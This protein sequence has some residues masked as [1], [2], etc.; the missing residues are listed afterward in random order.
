VKLAIESIRLSSFARSYR[1]AFRSGHGGRVGRL[2]QLAW[3]IRF[4]F[5]EWTGLGGREPFA[6]TL[7]IR[8]ESKTLHLNGRN[9]QTRCVYFSI[10]DDGYEV[11]VAMTIDRFL[12]DDGVFLDVGSNWGYFTL[13]VSSQAS[14]RGTIHA[15]E[16]MPGSYADL[17][18]VTGEAG[19]GKW[20]ET[21]QMAVGDRQGTVRMKDTR[22]SALAHV[23]DSEKGVEVPSGTIDQFEWDR[24]DVIKIDTEGYEL[25]ALQGAARSIDRCRPVIVFENETRNRS[26]ESLAPLRFLEERGY[27]LYR[28][29]ILSGELAFHP[30]LSGERDRHPPYANLVAIPEE[31]P[32]APE[33]ETPSTNGEP[34]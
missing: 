7:D 10:F 11:P 34:V 8:G 18:S 15:F 6:L 31:H 27:L 32:D 23:T 20:V 12:P 3:R 2:S 9:R 13:L 25:A 21:H 1:N 14:Y 22:H 33:R 26:A 17:V 30:V 4:Y 19:T 24:I 28:P 29:E 5:H 16:P